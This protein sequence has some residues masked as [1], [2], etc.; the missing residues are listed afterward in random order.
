MNTWQKDFW[1]LLEQHVF[2]QPSGP[3]TL[4]FYRHRAG[5][6]DPPGAP[7]VRR[8]NLQRYLDSLARPRYLLIGEA[9][10]PRGARFSGV[11]FTSEHQLETNLSELAGP[12]SSFGRAAY[13]EASATIFQRVM[14][15]YH[16]LYLAWNSYP[17][18]P[19]QPGQPQSIRPP[20]SG[21]MSRFN[22]LIL[23]LA[24]WLQPELV[25]AVGRRAESALAAA[26]LPHTYIRHPS[27]GGAAAF[28]AGV[29]GLL[30]ERGDQVDGEPGSA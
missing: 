10:G 18:L 21:E 12:R 8:R 26:G 22:F 13:K 5:P 15:P 28:E 20:T 16:R 9:P 4:N 3:K 1:R 27:H 30:P 19:H 6:F 24:E 23:R 11:P 25:L 14:A 7:A 29:R 17:L 2:P